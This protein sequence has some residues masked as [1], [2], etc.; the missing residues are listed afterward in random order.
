MNSLQVLLRSL[1]TFFQNSM[2]ESTYVSFSAKELHLEYEYL[3]HGIEHA[4]KI[5][6]R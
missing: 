6:N 3:Q 2:M 5:Y 4:R 1:L